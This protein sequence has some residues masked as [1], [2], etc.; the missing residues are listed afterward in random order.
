MNTPVTILLVDDHSVMRD[1]L[2]SLLQTQ[3]D[4]TVVGEASTG[5]QA[6]QMVKDLSPDV[7]VM[8][9]R[10]PDLNGF[11]AARQAVAAK[12]GLK[13]IALSGLSDDKSGAEMLRAGAVGFV[14]KESAFDELVDSHSHGH[15]E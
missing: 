7:V 11:D 1:G 12:P 5:R 13:V 6:I 2:R 8:D 4:L 9:V 15:Q 10:M 14:A 3:G